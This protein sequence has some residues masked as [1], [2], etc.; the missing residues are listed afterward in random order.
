MAWL[1]SLLNLACLLLGWAAW[2]LRGELRQRH[3]PATLAGTLRPA[4]VSTRR[5]WLWGLGALALLGLRSLL[6]WQG[7]SVS[8]W[9]PRV[10][11]VVLSLSFPVHP[12]WAGFGYLGIYAVL[13]FAVLSTGFFLWMILLSVLGQGAPAGNPFFQMI[14]SAVGPLQNWPAVAR[15]AVTL[16]GIAGLW[17]VIEPVLVALQLLPQPAPW[18]SR[19]LQAGLVALGSWLAWKPL[20]LGLLLLY[21]LN[22]YIYFGKHPFWEFVGW[23]GRRLVGPWRRLGLRV[24]KV[25]LTPLVLILVVWGLTHVAEQ[26]V[27]VQAW[28]RGL[29][30]LAELYAMLRQ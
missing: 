26:G 3:P 2:S 29:P 25:D 16:P 9:T 1:D 28:D 10:N 23:C 27:F 15:L 8:G 4:A 30:S 5:V 12:G 21:W 17:L 11:L 6:A 24:E 7:S 19:V 18:P 22:L 20:L 13:S 14:R